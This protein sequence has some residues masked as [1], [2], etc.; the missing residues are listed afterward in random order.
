[1]K[2]FTL[3]IYVYNNKLQKY[4]CKPEN[5]NKIVILSSTSA[6]AVQK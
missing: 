2:V 1:M 5:S 6:Y 4:I 3:V